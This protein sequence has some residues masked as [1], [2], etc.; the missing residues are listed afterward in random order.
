ML[1]IHHSYT[2]YLFVCII[3]VK[4]NFMANGCIRFSYR[5]ESNGDYVGGDD[6]LPFTAM[7]FF[8]DLPMGHTHGH[9]VYSFK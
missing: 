3:W 1:F 8:Q 2:Y 5:D 9:M 7:N 4:E 6:T